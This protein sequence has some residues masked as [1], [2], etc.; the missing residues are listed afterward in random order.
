MLHLSSK[1]LRFSVGGVV[2]AVVAAACAPYAGMTVSEDAN[3]TDPSTSASDEAGSSASWVF[4]ADVGGGD[5][6]EDDGDH[7]EA[8]DEATVNEAGADLACRTMT[9]DACVTCCRDS[10][11]TGATT[12]DGAYAR[13]ACGSCWLQCF[14][15]VCKSPP[16][17]PVVGSACDTCLGK[18]TC[19]V[20]T[21]STCMADG[22]CIAF[23]ACRSNC[24]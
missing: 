5:G 12:W 1:S 7:G 13:C 3:A 2:T 11:Q 9:K 17:Q 19:D 4:V 22:D 18:L 20:T 21:D 14:T 23:D 16:A 24:Q 10:H 8:S 6:G 15:S